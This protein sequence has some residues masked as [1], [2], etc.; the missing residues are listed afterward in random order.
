MKFLQIPKGSGYW[1][2]IFFLI[3]TVGFIA[4]GAFFIFNILFSAFGLMQYTGGII[5]WNFDNPY[6]PAFVI[7]S[8]GKVGLIA[9]ILGGLLATIAEGRLWIVPSKGQKQ[10]KSV[11]EKKGLFVL[12]SVIF[13]LYD[14]GSSFYFLSNGVI[15]NGSNGFFAG[16]LEF[17]VL[18]AATLLLFSIGPEMFM[19]WSFETMAA[20]WEEG[21][22]SL[23]SG[24]KIIISGIMGLFMSIKGAFDWETDD[25]EED[26]II[27]PAT[28]NSG[29]RGRGRPS[30]SVTELGDRTNF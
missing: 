10:P 6:I 9:G 13:V 11:M 18:M 24:V 28:N 17:F 15:F 20:N 27:M 19:V 2:G 7:V 16:L 14:I 8:G 5:T 22:P 30:N 1:A 4:A 29:K 3:G 21:I 26:D 23:A 25:D 12:F